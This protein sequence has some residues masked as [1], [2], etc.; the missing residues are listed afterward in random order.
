MRNLISALCLA[1]ALQGC[2]ASSH[3]INCPQ[4]AA[5]SFI[6]VSDVDDTVKVTNVPSFFAKVKNGLS[7]RLVFAGMPELY[8]GLLG[9]EEVSGRLEFVSGA[10]TFL[11]NKVTR[12][13]TDAG[14]PCYQLA[15]RAK[16]LKTSTE[17]FKSGY[18]A[19]THGMSARQFILIGDD[20]EKDPEVYEEFRKGRNVSAVYIH[21]ITGRAFAYKEKC[22]T[23]VMTAYDIALHEYRADPDRLTLDEAADVGEAVLTSPDSTFFPIFQK[24]PDE[25]AQTLAVLASPTALQDSQCPGQS[26]QAVALP[27]RLETLNRLIEQRIRALCLNRRPTRPRPVE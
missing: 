2:A 13:L 27:E 20:T 26:A 8:Q 1:V 18:L 16:P 9:E 19:G 15:L 21:R 11:R 10:P 24:C 7:S 17:R 23:A 4:T 6:L 3:L 5:D 14:F 25:S 12:V 22:M